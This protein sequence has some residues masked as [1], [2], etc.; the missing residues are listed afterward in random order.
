[1]IR[2]HQGNPNIAEWWEV[3]DDPQLNDLIQKTR[4][5]NLTLREAGLQIMQAKIQQFIANS[6]LL[7]QAQAFNEGF[8]R[9]FTSANGGSP[10]GASAT[11]GVALAPAPTLAPVVSAL[12]TPINGATP[13]GTGSTTTGINPQG[14]SGLI[15]SG[16]GGAGSSRFF[17]NLG[18]AGSL[19]WEIDFWGLFRRNIEA[20]NANLE[21]SAFNRDEIAVLLLA[22]TA[23]QYVQIRTFQ[24]R[25][26]LARSN[27]KLQ[28]PLVAQYKQRFEKGIANSAPGYHQLKSNLDNTRA[29]IPP[30]ETSLRQANNQLCVLMG[31]P[32]QDLV[33][34]LGDGTI[35]DPSDKTKRQVHIP[36]PKDEALV[37]D[38]PANILLK[39]PDVQAA[40]RQLRIQSAQVG[41]AEAEMFP[42]I[43]INGTIGISSNHINSLFSPNSWTGGIGPSLTWNILSYGRLLANVR[44]QNLQYQQFVAYYQN[45]ILNA[46]QDAENSIVAYLKSL[47]QAKY[48]RDSAE[49]SVKLTDYLVKQS[50]EGYLPPGAADTSA[51]IN[52]LF[53]AVNFQVQQQDAA[54]QAEGNVALNLILL[55][56]ALGGGW[57]V[58][59]GKENGQ[60]GPGDCS[61]P[62][63]APQANPPRATFGPPA[64]E[65]ALSAR[66]R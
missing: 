56:R 10:G 33:P 44:L 30:L 36:W 35:P 42:H 50:K 9:G 54:A 55:Y 7:P 63:A 11:A 40:E 41:I 26:D 47:D 59:E 3:F 5:Q 60:S 46:N 22:N 38:I 14:S 12:A 34:S 57:E 4:A 52:Q 45:A 6:E 51:F 48:L 19:A 15:G 66:P 25:L 28:E 16:I 23:T 27:V 18:L 31:I 2:F 58:H 62:M 65:E 61:S 21:Q 1:M 64:P 49:A 39:R 24:K 13:T 29:L 43:G 32:I 20:A 53:T 37:I 17:S 8:T